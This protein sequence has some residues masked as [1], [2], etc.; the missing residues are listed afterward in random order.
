MPSRDPRIDTYIENSAPY[1]APILTRIRETV[2]AACPDVEETFKWSHPHFM[3]KGMLCAMASFKAHCSFGFWKGRAVFG[4]DLVD[5]KESMGHFGRLTAVGDLPSKT[6][7]TRYIK[8]AM[9]LNED[10]VTVPR[11]KKKPA[12]PLKV[13]P[14][15]TRALAKNRKA[16]ATFDAFSPSKRKDYVEWITEARTDATR[17]KRLATAIEWM[18]E[19]K[20]RNWKYENC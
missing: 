15:L 5:A 11:R 2:H 1:A 19:G 13:P 10:G 20:S 14:V 18:A 7:L 16:R 9:Q 6:V 12:V 4:D 17:D 8:K 3:Y